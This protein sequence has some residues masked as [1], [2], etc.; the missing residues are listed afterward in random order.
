MKKTFIGEIYGRFTLLLSCLLLG[1]ACQEVGTQKLEKVEVVQLE[2]K[3]AEAKPK[4]IKDTLKIINATF[5]GNKK[6][7]YFGSDAPDRLNV[8]WK[9]NLGKGFTIVTAKDGKVEWKGAGW[10]GQPLMVREKDEYFLIQ[11]A[12]DHRLKKI[13]AKTGELVWEYTFDNVIKGTGTIWEDHQ[14]KDPQNSIMI[15]QGARKNINISLYG[16]GIYSFR[17]ISYFTGKELW[18][19]PISKGE[20][21]SRDVDAS[22]LVI[23][24]K[25]Y[26]PTENGYLMILNP[27]ELDTI[28][29]D[30]STHFQPKIL[31][32][33][34]LF[35]KDD[36]K[37]H[38]GNLVPESSPIVMNGKLYVASGAGHIYE[39]DPK[40]DSVTWRFDIGSDLDGTPAVTDDNKLLIPIEKQYIK[41]LGGVI[42][43]DPSKEGREAVEWFFPTEDKGFKSWEGGVIGSVINFK[44]NNEEF[45]AFTGL[46]GWFYILYT[47]SLSGDDVLGFD[48]ENHYNSPKLAKKIKVGPSIATP[49]F[50]PPNRFIIAG[51]NGVY[52]L[53]WREN[54]L[55]RLDFFKGNFESTPF[56]YDQKAYVASRNGFFY[57][58]GVDSSQ[59]KVKQPEEEILLAEH[60]PPQTEQKSDLKNSKQE[61][62]KSKQ[63]KT[64]SPSS[65][66]D[67]HV[68]AGAFGNPENAKRKL[69]ELKSEGFAAKII[70]GRKNLDY[71]IMASFDNQDKARELAKK[72]D[73]WVYSTQE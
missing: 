31:K 14:A 42:K 44:A 2:V 71:V 21:Y 29:T 62:Q 40:L 47:D 39:I 28:K 7:N 68:V 26:V 54:N 70:K 61:V 30:T 36:A 4:P 10:T 72:H 1:Y 15:L 45:C 43:L 57:C 52:L 11:G 33:I 50:V 41:G 48:G 60:T 35:E 6:R 46:D 13:N 55:N 24:D 66:G 53:E 49:L 17:A 32:E 12:Y 63:L 20:S 56:V 69:K 5:L 73:L 25:V 9:Y 64:P 27:Y 51:Y 8:L 16:D 18:R 23:N 58:F 22:A 34:E 59:F 38:R 19:V 67:Y 3:N 65:K 37:I